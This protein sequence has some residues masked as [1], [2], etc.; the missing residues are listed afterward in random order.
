MERDAHVSPA[1][2]GNFKD[3]QL[4]RYGSGV[5]ATE[6]ASSRCSCFSI[7]SSHLET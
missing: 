1:K 7:S 2:L 6:W 5:R 3:V 4:A